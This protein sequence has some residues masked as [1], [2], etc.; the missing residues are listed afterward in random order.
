MSKEGVYRGLFEGDG[1]GAGRVGE[2]E[3]ERGCHELTGGGGGGG[4][5]F[6]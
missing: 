6:G 5:S 4:S 3:G 1:W 2:R